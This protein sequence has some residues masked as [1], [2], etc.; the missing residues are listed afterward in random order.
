VGGTAGCY[1]SSSLRRDELPFFFYKKR[2]EWVKMKLSCVV[3]EAEITIPSGAVVGELF[4]CPDCG[5]EL[6]LVSL[7]PPA[8]E[9]A[10]QVEEDWGE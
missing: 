9:E 2:K 5:T 4:I 6:E 1:G 3:C 10:P 7:D 8:V